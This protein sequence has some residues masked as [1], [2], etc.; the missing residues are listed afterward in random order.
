M[1]FLL[2][3]D[4]GSPS[5]RRAGRMM[6]SRTDTIVVSPNRALPY[7]QRRPDA[8]AV[9]V[10]F[11]GGEIWTGTTAAVRIAFGAVEDM[12]KAFLLGVDDYLCCPWAP[13]ELTVR[14][15]RLVSGGQETLGQVLVLGDTTV[16]V[17]ASQAVIWRYLSARPGRVVGRDILADIAG[18]VTDGRDY[19]R[20]VDMQI[21]RLRRALGAYGNS[22]ETVRG[23]GY[24]V[25]PETVN[26][27]NL[28]VDK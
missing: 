5:V 6:Q 25:N 17:S 24:R 20:A 21:A 8:V 27:S 1:G 26:I 28:I 11:I 4:D 13:V 14:V 15:Q 16:V 10:S 9:P 19:S 23:K 18:L 12:E 22:I 2:V 3:V 7:L